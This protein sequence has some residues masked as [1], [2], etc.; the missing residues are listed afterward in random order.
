MSETGKAPAD[1]ADALADKVNNNVSRELWKALRES[2]A[3]NARLRAGLQMIADEIICP[4][5][6]PKDAWDSWSEAKQLHMCALVIA[7]VSLEGK[8]DG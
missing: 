2:C 5:L 1:I 3:D 4:E 8:V 6:W 7:Q